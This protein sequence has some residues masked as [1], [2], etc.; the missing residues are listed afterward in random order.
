MKQI[1]NTSSMSTSSESSPQLTP[2]SSKSFSSLSMTRMS[3]ISNTQILGMKK[4]PHSTPSPIS[5][6]C[7]VRSN[8]RCHSLMRRRCQ[9]NGPQRLT[10]KSYSIKPITYFTTPNQSLKSCLTSASPALSSILSQ[11]WDDSTFPFM[12]GA[13]I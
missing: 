2:H 13:R 5:A 3:T 12:I 8:P 7:T 9:Q 10:L 11:T 6:T 4:L 1:N